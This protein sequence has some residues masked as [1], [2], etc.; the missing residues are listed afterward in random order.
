VVSCGVGLSEVGFSDFVNRR[1]LVRFQSQAPGC[2]GAWR[3]TK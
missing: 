1:S 3:L 2:E